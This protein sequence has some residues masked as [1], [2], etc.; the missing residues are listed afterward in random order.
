MQVLFYFAPSINSSTSHDIIESNPILKPLRACPVNLLRFPFCNGKI[1]EQLS[2]IVRELAPDKRRKLNEIYFIKQLTGVVGEGG[3]GGEYKRRLAAT[4]RTTRSKD[5][6]QPLSCGAGESNGIRREAT[7]TP[8]SP[9]CS[10]FSLCLSLS[11][12]ELSLSLGI[13]GVYSEC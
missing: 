10:C 7:A 5:L 1:I 9:P 13:C 3:E 8:P 11:H 2:P 4:R 6:L 12:W